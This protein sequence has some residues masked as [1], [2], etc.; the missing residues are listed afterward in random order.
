[1]QLNRDGSR[2]NEV[3]GQSVRK[4]CSRWAGVL[5]V[6]KKRREYVYDPTHAIYATRVDLERGK[7]SLAIVL[8]TRERE[9][10]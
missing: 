10:T 8:L 1:M 7:S 6:L 3:E 2:C 4:M 9:S 5:P